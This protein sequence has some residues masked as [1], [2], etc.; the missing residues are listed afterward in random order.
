V[1]TTNLARAVSLNGDVRNLAKTDAEF[2]KYLS[3]PL[4]EGAI[5]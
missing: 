3:N 5:R 2:L 4:F 1:L